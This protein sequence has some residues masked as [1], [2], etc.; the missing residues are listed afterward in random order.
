MS[1]LLKFEMMRE[2]IAPLAQG[3]AETIGAT[4]SAKDTT[5]NLHPSIC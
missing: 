1:I 3:Q 4:A 2:C 5:R